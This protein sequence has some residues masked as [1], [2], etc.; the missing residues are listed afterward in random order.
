MT[1]DSERTEVHDDLVLVTGATGRQG[2]AVA[3]HLLKGGRPVRALTR[4]A[5]SESARQLAAAGAQIVIGDM[6]VAGTLDA[7]LDG[8]TTVFSVQDF[9]AKGVGYDGEVAQGTNLARAAKRAGVAHYV[10][11]TMAATPDPGDVEHFRS[12]FAIEQVVESL[13]L[14]YTF[15]GTVW[16][17]DNVIDPKRV[18]R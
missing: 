8:V 11:S 14:P 12:K 9:Y 6:G 17:M 1:M 5:G 15:I 3:R 18:G 16:F 4:S 7:A 10:Q 2:G 13:G